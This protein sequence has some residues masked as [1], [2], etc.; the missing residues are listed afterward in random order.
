M[1]W[2]IVNGISDSDSL[3][4]SNLMVKAVIEKL[5]QILL[6]N[7]LTIIAHEQNSMNMAIQEATKTLLEIFGLS[8]NDYGQMI[9][10]NFQIVPQMKQMSQMRLQMI[11][12]TSD[13]D[14]TSNTDKLDLQELKKIFRFKLKIFKELTPILDNLKS[15]CK[16]LSNQLF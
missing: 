2:K 15:K 10:S 16:L 8:E 3:K 7:F 9:Q 13:E 12:L 4:K 1:L 5:D 6:G 11:I 14:T